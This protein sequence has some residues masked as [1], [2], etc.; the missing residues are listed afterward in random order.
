MKI[1]K[2][3]EAIEMLTKLRI[4][5]IKKSMPEFEQK[6]YEVEMKLFGFYDDNYKT[7]LERGITIKKAKP[8]SNPSVYLNPDFRKELK[9]RRLS[10]G[11]SPN[12]IYLLLGM[13][14]STL[15]NIEHPHINVRPLSVKK[16]DDFYTQKEKE[17]FEQ[18]Q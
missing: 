13:H 18:N 11:L 12:R 1:E 8:T 15:S 4:E 10:L 16:L 6:L 2:I 9:K 5:S 14:P 7:Q 17:F 3:D